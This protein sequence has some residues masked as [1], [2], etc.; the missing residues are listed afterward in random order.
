MEFDRK[1]AKKQIY[2]KWKKKAVEQFQQDPR[3]KD[4]TF[5]DKEYKAIKS[6]IFKEYY[7]TIGV[8]TLF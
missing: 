1:K 5:S 8:P 2:K 3:H 4:K 6:E 7:Q